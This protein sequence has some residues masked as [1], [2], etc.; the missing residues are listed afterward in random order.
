[1]TMMDERHDIDG[2]PLSH[3]PTE[4]TSPE[5]NIPIRSRE[6][7]ALEV[8]RKAL[9]EIEREYGFGVHA[10]MRARAKTALAD[11]NTI[12]NEGEP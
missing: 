5:L 2:L 8:A 11:I 6:A 12:L 10:R 9:R 4:A 1:M 3:D 7:A